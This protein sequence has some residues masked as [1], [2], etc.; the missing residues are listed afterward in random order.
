MSVALLLFAVACGV[1]LVLGVVLTPAAGALAKRLGAVAHPS[2]NRWNRRPVPY[3][4][5]IAIFAGTV[6]GAV[7]AVALLEKLPF[8]GGGTAAGHLAVVSVSAAMMFFVGLVDD[9]VTLRPQLKFILQ[10][11]AGLLLVGFGAI[12]PLT[13]WYTVNALVTLF[14]FVGITNAFNLLDNMDGVA[15]GVGAVASFFLGLA[16]AR[17]GA[18]LGASVAW[19]LMGA[20]LGFLRYNFHPAAIFM[21]DAGSLF[22]GAS[23][24]GLAVLTPSLSGNLVSVMFVPLIIL[25]VPILDTGLVTVTRLLTGRAVSQGG[26]DHTAHRLVTLGL[27]ERR[28]A[29]LLYTFAALGGLV[30]LALTGLDAGLG[31]LLGTGFLVVLGIAAA[32]LGRMQVGYSDPSRGSK[33]M[34]VLIAQLLYKRRLA[35][36]LLDVA[37]IVLAYYGTFRLKFDHGVPSEYVELFRATLGFVIFIKV[38]ALGAFGVYRGAWKYSSI[39]ELCR[40]VGAV[41]VSAIAVFLVANWMAP[42]LPGLVSIVVIDALLVSAFVLSSRLSFRSLEVLRTRLEVR[43]EPVLFYG[44]GDAGEFALREV[45][46]N[47]NLR[48]RPACF[49]DD[50]PQKHGTQI[51][52][53][54]VIGGQE[55]L[56]L[57]VQL[58]GVSKIVIGTKLLKPDVMATLCEFAKKQ[59]LE[60]VELDF[61]F[62][63]VADDPAV[64]IKPHMELAPDRSYAEREAFPPSAREVG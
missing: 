21:G 17:Q 42:A 59:E 47:A 55:S 26:R 29:L 20:T 63:R 52:G 54:P 35:Q 49:I 53:V 58:F 64:T 37:L 44:A 22:I 8:V 30:A 56:A 15:A 10:V 25:A 62:R 45:M 24:A 61:A 33:R 50:D 40:I 5:G 51:H 3:L 12:L 32:Y 60:L 2:E 6:L 18:W 14:W 34:T 46:N 1:S 16:L 57:A 23:L 9:I 48:M 31:F 11:V 19:A 13:P 38:V 28:V 39:L 43:G 41:V 27:S 4:G 7:G 36:L